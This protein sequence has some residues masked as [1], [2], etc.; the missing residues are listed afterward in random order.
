MNYIF[1]QIHIYT[2]ISFYKPKFKQFSKNKIKNKIH[3]KNINK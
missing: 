1:S 3:K 2:L